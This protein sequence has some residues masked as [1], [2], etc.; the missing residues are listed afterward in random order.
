MKKSNRGLLITAIVFFT[1]IAVFLSGILIYAI[2]SGGNLS[3]FRNDKSQVVFD[4]NFESAGVSKVTVSTSFGNVNIKQSSSDKIRVYTK[5]GNEEFFSAVRNN[6]VLTIENKPVKQGR[7]KP[8]SLFGNRNLPSDIDIY[9]PENCLNEIEISSDFGNVNID[10]LNNVSLRVDCSMGNI[11]ADYLSGDFDVN[12]DMG[13]VEI[14]KINIIK[15]S[16]ASSSMGNIEIES[17]NDIRV[18]YDTSMGDCDIEHNNPSS[19][20]TLKAKT[21]MGDVEI[22]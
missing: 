19:S 2:C 12:T 5:D 13:N 22:G 10:S 6:G 8:Y 9:I 14:D 18:D 1:G 15:D 16:S 11:E 21:S 3:F 4:E 17:T 7:I 20:V